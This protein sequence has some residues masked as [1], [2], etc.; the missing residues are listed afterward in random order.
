MRPVTVALLVLAT[1]CT[2]GG[3]DRNG[4]GD[5]SGDTDDEDSGGGNAG[6]WR[7][8]GGGYA[9]FV[10]GAA[11]NS[12]VHLELTRCIPPLEGEAYY[13]FLSKG[14]SSPIALGEL[15][16]AGEE[17]RFEGESGVDALLGG[18][19]TFDAYATAGDGGAPDGTH[20]WTGQIDP[21]L[22]AVIEEL[23]ISSSATPEGE[24]TL[25]SAE[26]EIEFVIEYTLDVVADARSVE[27]LHEEGERIANAI[28]GGAEDIDDDG[29]VSLLEG[30]VGL[31]GAGGYVSRV[32]QDLETVS[33]S[34]AVGDPIKDYANYA[35]DCIQR[36]ES[37]A[38]FAAV[39]ARVATV[40]GAESSCDDTLGG[41]VTE[42]GVAQA[43]ADADGDGGVDPLTEGT[44]EC[45][46]YYVSQMARMS[47]AVP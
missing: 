42:L 14:G 16:C 4:S 7:P 43:G 29:T 1:G 2:S 37:H 47:V 44:I 6:D 25:R 28:E 9:W 31:L 41:V 23:V 46:I 20:L 5:D 13:G 19:D 39:S 35:Y 33:G 22:L 10:D 30:T 3:K 27:D 38:E 17:V 12:V 26:T 32:I 24:G 34:V 15:T 36:V 40:C 45:S 8:V 18:Y 21:A 11:D